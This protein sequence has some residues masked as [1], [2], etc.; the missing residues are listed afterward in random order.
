MKGVIP[1]CALKV[2]NGHTHGGNVCTPPKFNSSPLKNDGWKMSFL[3]GLSIFRGYVKFP[4]CKY[5]LH[6]AFGN[7]H[8]QT[9]LNIGT[10]AMVV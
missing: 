9:T 4:G 8:L 7:E 2:K 6:G 10:L 5:S 1:R 3:L